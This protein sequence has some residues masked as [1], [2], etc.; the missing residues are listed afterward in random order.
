MSREMRRL[1][2][3]IPEDL[4]EKLERIVSQRN[5]GRPAGAPPVT[6]ADLIFEAVY[7]LVE[8]YIAKYEDPQD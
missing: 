1:N 6:K 3:E 2:I 5:E 8:D 4:D 7:T